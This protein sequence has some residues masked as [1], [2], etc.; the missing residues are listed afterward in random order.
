[1]PDPYPASLPSK[2]DYRDFIRTLDDAHPRWSAGRF[3]NEVRDNFTHDT[4]EHAQG[5]LISILWE[6]VRREKAR[7]REQANTRVSKRSTYKTPRKPA[8]PGH[9]PDMSTGAGRDAARECGC[10]KCL[11]YLERYEYRVVHGDEVTLGALRIV[12]KYAAE[13]GLDLTPELLNSEIA[14]GD[15]TETT[16]GHAT[17]EDFDKRLHMLSIQ[18]EGTLR[19]MGRLQIARDMLVEQNAVT[20]SEIASREKGGS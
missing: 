11:S 18:A 12:E 8:T 9:I 14:L 5:V 13:H 16:W 19:T 1:M 20:L 17:I 15:N 3:I 6:Q 7:K 4:K 10:K 2:A